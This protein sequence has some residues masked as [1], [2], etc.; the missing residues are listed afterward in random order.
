M[1]F[2]CVFQKPKNKNKKGTLHLN[3]DTNII[4]YTYIVER[5]IKQKL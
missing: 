4:V 1:Y 2:E 5:S 3:P